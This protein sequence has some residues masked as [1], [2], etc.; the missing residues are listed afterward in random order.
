MKIE[1]E[2]AEKADAVITVSN[3]TK[4]ILVEKYGIDEKKITT[5]Y[6]GVKIFCIYPGTI[7][8][9]GKNDP[10]FRKDN[11]PERA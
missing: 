1:K 8:S 11:K 5:V 4:R 2:G 9:K 6:N 10:L 3:L 7:I